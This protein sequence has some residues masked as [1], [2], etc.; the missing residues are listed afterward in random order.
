VVD[1]LARRGFLRQLA[2]LPLIGGGVTLLGNPTGAAE[3]VTEQLL[4]AYS[5]WLFYERRLLCVERYPGIRHPDGFIP[6]NTGASDYHFP[7]GPERWQDRP[8][9][10]T[11]AAVVLASVGCRWKEGV[12]RPLTVPPDPVDRLDGRRACFLPQCNC[13]VH[14]TGE[15]GFSFGR[16][17]PS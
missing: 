8:M 16:L 7:L 9:P 11:R 6:A 2:G 1:L 13:P 17:L 5:E 4:D 14:L 12:Y 15:R 10:S 3:P